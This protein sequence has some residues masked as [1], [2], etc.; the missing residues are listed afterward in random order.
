MG[1]TQ[2]GHPRGK[3][4]LWGSGVMGKLSGLLWEQGCLVL[5]WRPPAPQEL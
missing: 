3:G 2:Q 5:P 1:S 4:L